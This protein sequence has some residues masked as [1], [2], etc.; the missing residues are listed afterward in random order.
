MMVSRVQLEDMSRDIVKP[1]IEYKCPRLNV[2]M[3]VLD[4]P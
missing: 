1:E 3:A 2:P 4:I